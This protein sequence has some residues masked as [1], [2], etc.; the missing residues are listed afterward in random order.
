[1]AA[2]DLAAKR[3]SLVRGKD[4]LLNG[5]AGIPV[6]SWTMAR[7]LEVSVVRTVVGAR[8][9]ALDLFRGFRGAAW[10]E[11][12]GAGAAFPP[13]SAPPVAGGW[14]TGDPDNNELTLLNSPTVLG[15]GSDL[16][17]AGPIHAEFGLFKRERLGI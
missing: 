17:D 3:S 11:F 15:F 5:G 8:R 1:M 14:K 4:E 9:E 6:N 7:K 12:G 2:P 13:F 16:K 10:L